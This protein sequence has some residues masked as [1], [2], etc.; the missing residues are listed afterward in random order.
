[1]LSVGLAEAEEQQQ[2]PHEDGS[3]MGAG[4]HAQQEADVQTG[5]PSGRALRTLRCRC[6]LQRGQL[7]PEQQGDQ[8]G[9]YGHGQRGPPAKVSKHVGTA[10]APRPGHHQDGWRGKV[11]ERA[12]YRNIDQQHTQ[13]GVL[14]TR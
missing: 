13:R 4:H 11:A 14:Q 3:V 5:H 8:C 1:M 9:I 10:P 2:Q 12:A 6:Y 7:T